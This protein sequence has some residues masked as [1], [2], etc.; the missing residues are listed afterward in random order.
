M[1]MRLMD[2]RDELEE[3]IEGEGVDPEQASK[4]TDVAQYGNVLATL[5]HQP[6]AN[7]VT[8]YILKLEHASDFTPDGSH[9][10]AEDWSHVSDGLLWASDQLQ[11]LFAA[12]QLFGGP[13]DEQ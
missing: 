9:L 7:G 13:D 1:L 12:L 3:R 5:W 8:S 10:K 6:S 4:L 2:E 11:F